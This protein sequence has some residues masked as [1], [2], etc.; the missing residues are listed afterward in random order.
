MK[1]LAK[2]AIGCGI[3]LVLAGVATIALVVGG[4]WWL[5]GKAEEVID[6]ET[7]V[8]EMKRQAEATGP[9]FTPPAD[10]VIQEARL[11]KFLEAR[12]RVYAIYEEHKDEFEAAKRQETSDVRDVLKGVAWLNEV[13]T[14][15][16]EAQAAVG[17]GDAEYR[18]IA[19][20]VYKTWWA[21]EVAQQTG[22]KS[23]S[24]V[25]EESHDQMAEAM[26]QAQEQMKD[27]PPEQREAFEK[28][29]RESEQSRVQTRQQLESLQVPKANLDLFRKHEAQI[30]KYAMGGLEL[31]GL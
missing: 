1:T 28:A 19:E 10:G 9:A 16:A 23:V 2:V 5:K 29:M 26:R 3:V 4:A 14:A 20:A 7:K 11:L 6:N 18:F 24:E 27:L 22:G 8:Q 12:R 31:L 15:Q 13:R 21:A 25:A 30:K 17:M